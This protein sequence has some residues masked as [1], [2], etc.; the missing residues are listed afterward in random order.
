MVCGAVVTGGGGVLWWGEVRADGGCIW[1]VV[2]V[3][4]GF[5]GVGGWA[6]VGVA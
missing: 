2:G 6:V 3:G 5:V 4:R 1:G